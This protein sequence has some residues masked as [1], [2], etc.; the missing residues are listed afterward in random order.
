MIETS[1]CSRL[2]VSYLLQCAIIPRHE[3]VCLSIRR[4]TACSRARQK[5]CLPLTYPPSYLH[6]VTYTSLPTDRYLHGH[7]AHNVVRRKN[8]LEVKPSRL[9]LQPIVQNVLCLE[10]FK[11][12]M[13]TASPNFG[14]R[15]SSGDDM[16][17]RRFLNSRTKSS[18]MVHLRCPFAT[19]SSHI[20]GLYRVTNSHESST[21][22]RGREVSH[23]RKS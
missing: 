7:L 20:V 15:A 12:E 19:L 11:R 23:G 18:A 3:T 2:A 14:S 8:R 13:S 22:Y 10:I 17:F 21:R 1:A 4:P 16:N 6:I 9:H 5:R